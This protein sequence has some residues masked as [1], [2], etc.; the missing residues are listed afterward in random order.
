MRRRCIS[1]P[2]DDSYIEIRQSMYEL[3]ED[4]YVAAA[5]VSYF[6]FWH[7]NKL[8][9]RSK[10]KHE[11]DIAESHNEPKIHSLSLL[12]FHTSDELENNIIVAKKDTLRKSVMYLVS[13]G[14][15]SIHANPNENFKF[16]KTKYYLFHPETL[17]R[18][19]DTKNRISGFYR[20]SDDFK[21]GKRSDERKIVYA[22][23]ENLNASLKNRLPIT[24]T[25]PENDSF[26]LTLNSGKT[27]VTRI[28]EERD[29]FFTSG[30]KI[31]DIE[32]NI[33]RLME[34]ITQPLIVHYNEEKLP[35]RGNKQI[36]SIPSEK[37]QEFFLQDRTAKLIPMYL[38]A[39]K[40]LWNTKIMMEKEEADQKN[41][42]EENQPDG[43]DDETF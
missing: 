19:I 10:F 6:E 35:L 9:N 3:L 26:S 18:M 17:Q 7:T 33:G 12:Q 16:D 38:N 37:I 25:I 1:Y 5:L 29:Q 13:K 40:V 4:D 27:D 43:P 14:I 42:L 41:Y 24:E 28:H 20:L 15:L 2:A 22:S 21:A 39:L 32:Q 23:S 11:N 31:F 8:V 30:G 36:L 34:N